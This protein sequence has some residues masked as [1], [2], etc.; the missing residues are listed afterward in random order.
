MKVWGSHGVGYWISPKFSPHQSLTNGELLWWHHGKPPPLEVQHGSTQREEFGPQ[1]HASW[2]KYIPREACHTQFNP[3]P[4]IHI[5]KPSYQKWT[6]WKMTHSLSNSIIIIT[7][8]TVCCSMSTCQP[9][10]QLYLKKN[11]GIKSTIITSQSLGEKTE[12]SN[13]EIRGTA[14]SE[15][16]ACRSNSKSSTSKA[17]PLSRKDDKCLV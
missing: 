7:Q 5:L 2:P 11:L 3:N 1:L 4:P 6:F 16:K 15:V 13:P 10:E 14:V 17:Q 9:L 12:A 8:L